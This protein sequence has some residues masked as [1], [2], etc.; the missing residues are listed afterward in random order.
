MPSAL[1]GPAV[2]AAAGAVPRRSEGRR[3]TALMW[4]EWCGSGDGNEVGAEERFRCA[5]SLGLSASGLG[6]LRGPDPIPVLR[7]GVQVP[8]DDGVA[9]VQRDDAAEGE[10]RAEGDLGLAPLRHSHA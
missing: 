8:V 4:W 9:R 1:S 7:E 2:G 10:E 6:H 3:L 5:L